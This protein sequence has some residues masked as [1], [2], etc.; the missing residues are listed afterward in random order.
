MNLPPPASALHDCFDAGPD[1]LPLTEAVSRLHQRLSPVC[2][3]ETVPLE[4]A[5]G[6]VLAADVCATTTVPPHDNSAVDGY[7]FA[8][9]SLNGTSPLPVIRRVAAG[10]PP[11]PA[12]PVGSAVRIFTGAPMPPGTDSVAMQE[13]CKVS[14]ATDPS[15]PLGWVSLPPS[16]SEGSNRRRAGED[17]STGATVLWQGRRLRGMD[18][19]MAA[20]TGHPTLP[21]YCPLNVA[22]FSTG[23]E[24]RPPG[25]TLEPGQ[26]YDSNRFGVAGLLNSMGCAVTDL[27][28]L[29]D[30]GPTIQAAMRDAATHHQLVI[31]S[32]GVSMGEEDHVKKA[33]EALGTLHFWRLAMK[34]GRPLA[35]GSL[36]DSV[37]LGL[38]GNPVAALVSLMVLGRALIHCLQGRPQ[39]PLRRYRFPAA[40]AFR[41]KPGRQEFI[42][43]WI[44]DEDDGRQ[45]VHRFD[46]QGSGVLSSMVR[47]DGLVDIPADS[48]SIKPGDIVDYIP[49]AEALW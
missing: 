12:V 21:V 46:S 6:R 41:K 19:A 3:T 15:A 16:L 5:T 2:A 13:D 36:G 33:I 27:G 10:D 49:F 43:T 42:R 25:T 11:G 45:T 47:A 38:P 30:D 23:D 34:P 22:L 35:L 28:A 24:L 31:T 18:L 32:G 37:F 1:L 20:A 7:A 8:A 26:I 48:N 29:P 9:G 44:E 39:V 17:V 14:D 4:Q 40:F